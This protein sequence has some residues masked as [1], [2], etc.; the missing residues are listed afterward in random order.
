MGSGKTLTRKGFSWKV[1]ETGFK[2][3]Q[4][5]IKILLEK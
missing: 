5:N 3:I 1:S 2:G 4:N